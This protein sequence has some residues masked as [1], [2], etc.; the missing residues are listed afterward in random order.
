[1]KLLR[2][3]F[4]FIISIPVSAQIQIG[5]DIDGEAAGD[6]SGESVSLSSDGTTLAIGAYGNV[7]NGTGTNAGHVRIYEYS[8]GSWTQLG[9]DIDGEAAADNSGS[10]VSLSSG[11]DTVAIGAP[12]NDGNGISSGHV[13]VYSLVGN[14]AA[15]TTNHAMTLQACTGDIVTYSFDIT[16][17]FDS[18]NTFRVELSNP[19]TTTFSGN[20]I[21]INPLAAHQAD[22][23]YQIAV[24]IPD[25][26]I[27]Q[28]YSVR[29]V[30]TSPVLTDGVINNII[31]GESPKP[32]LSY[33]SNGVLNLIGNN[34]TIRACDPDTVL[35]TVDSAIVNSIGNNGTSTW[36]WY[37]SGSPIAG[38]TNDS[39]ALIG[40]NDQGGYYVVESGNL[41]DGES[42]TINFEIE[43]YTGLL[44][45]SALY[46]NPPNN[47]TVFATGG[48]NYMW[49]ADKPVFVDDVTNDSVEVALM[50]DSTT[51]FVDVNYGV[52]CLYQN[53]VFLRDTTVI[54][55]DVFDTIP[56]FDTS[57]VDVFDTIAY[58]DTTHID[59]YDT[60]FVTNIDTVTL[61][62]TDT[63]IIDVSLV[64]L[65]P[66]SFEYQVKV[67]PN[68]TRDYILIDVPADMISQSYFIE[69]ANPL[70]QIVYYNLMNQSQLQIN[71]SSLGA[72]GTYVLKL[73]DSSLNLVDK[74]III[75]Q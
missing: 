38:A 58:Y 21:D 49:S 15:A 12:Y 11:G 27:Q 37:K 70:G 20:Y 17:D 66:L 32:I 31:I 4:F 62:V 69:L 34:D 7:G 30:S 67:Y 40:F 13:R 1:M 42:D 71:I 36:Q 41:C 39:L 50:S 43:T 10:F 46:Y 64:G 33:T 16:G 72:T 63:L 5:S 24:K 73:Y 48:T 56:V 19:G 75:L 53:S 45:A 18:T 2:L 29:L 59:V 25:T 61:T 74:R 51:L 68:P 3:L 6:F 60:L 44:T 26:L 9:A 52:N 23:N 14:Y 55:C 57:F 35:L 65:N 22:T 54:L 47:I 28:L 8:A